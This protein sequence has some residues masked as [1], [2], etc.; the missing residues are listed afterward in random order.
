MRRTRS[1]EDQEALAGRVRCER[2]GGEATCLGWSG[3]YGGGPAPARWEIT[4][5]GCNGGDYWVPLCGHSGLLKDYPEYADWDRHLSRKTDF[6][7]ADW[8]DVLSRLA[9]QLGVAALT[10]LAEL[11]GRPAG[12]ADGRE[13]E[14]H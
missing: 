6:D 8:A 4:C 7:A 12:A 2:C 3:R 13:H 11:G 9:R 14:T 1:K 10:D 5:G